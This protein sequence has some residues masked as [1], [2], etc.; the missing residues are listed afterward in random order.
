MVMNVAQLPTKQDLLVTNLHEVPDYEAF[1]QFDGRMY[2]GRL[3]SD[4]NNNGGTTKKGSSSSSSYEDAADTARTGQMMFWLFE[5]T[6]QKIPDT[7]II[8][9]NGGPG[10]SSFNCGVLMEICTLFPSSAVC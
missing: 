10:C 3:P 7:M 4:N 6:T 5:P 1:G 8:W 9:L 2:A